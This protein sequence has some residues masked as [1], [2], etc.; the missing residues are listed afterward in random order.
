MADEGSQAEPPQAGRA[1]WSTLPARAWQ[2]L[3]G[4]GALAGVIL[5]VAGV[6]GLFSDGDESKPAAGPVVDRIEEASARYGSAQTRAL[7]LR[8]VV[9]FEPGQAWHSDSRRIEAAL[10]A[11]FPDAVESWK[12]Y[13]QALRTAQLVLDDNATTPGSDFG[14]SQAQRLVDFAGTGNPRVLVDPAHPDYDLE[15]ATV[16]GR[17]DEHKAKIVDGLLDD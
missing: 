2:V 17:L 6:L 5:S 8:Q 3:L 10:R 1:R 15:W 11:D 4:I 9:G 14:L 12:R 13:D 7:A 16:L